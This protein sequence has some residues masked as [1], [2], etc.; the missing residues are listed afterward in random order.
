MR[1][2]LARSSSSSSSSSPT[3][4]YYY[5]HVFVVSTV[6]S[7]VSLVYTRPA[8]TLFRVD[9]DDRSLTVSTMITTM[10]ISST[11]LKDIKPGIITTTPTAST[12]TG[13]GTLL[14]VSPDDYYMEL[15]EDNR[16][17]QQE[18]RM[19]F[20]QSTVG[21]IK[22]PPIH[23]DLETDA[24]TTGAA[25]AAADDD[26]HDHDVIKKK[27][28]TI[29]KPGSDPTRTIVEHEH[30]K[31]CGHLR[32]QWLRN[33]PMSRLAKS[34]QHHQ[35]NC[36]LPIARHT[37][38]NTFGLGSH[39][40][41]W[42]QA[43]CNAIEDGFR[44]TE[45][46]SHVDDLWIWQDQG[47]CNTNTDP[48]NK[49]NGDQNPTQQRISASSPMECY[50]PVTRRNKCPISSS[51]Q[52]QHDSSIM[53]NVTDP[54]LEK[55]WCTLTR[56]TDDI[57]QKA[58]VRASLTEYLFSEISPLVVKEA[59][60]QIGII[61]QD[62]GSQ[63]PNDLVTVH[64]RWG[65]KFWEMDLPSID[66]YIQGVVRVLTGSNETI[67]PTANI[68]LATEDPKAYKAFIDAK[69]PGWKVFADITLQEIDA[70]RPPKG[71]RASWATRNTQGRAGF[72]AMGSLLV[73]LEAK[74]FVLTTKSNW[75]TMMNHLRTN[76]V[77]PRCN[78]CTA[79][80]DLRPGVW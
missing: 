26:D 38:D 76:I 16:Q 5:F 33:P 49:N 68:F 30:A 55:Q 1:A 77:D 48:K 66:E 71:N 45:Q 12:K 73:S 28:N 72:I 75:S 29:K 51:S 43:L 20:L 44:M 23:L 40:S 79:M 52:Q 10:K 54:R 50:L 65:D 42:G 21:C 22:H 3:G 39:F 37:L 13:E 19:V 47:H 46:L 74:Y 60:R 62:V 63:V 14:T 27:R 64:I 8:L 9:N 80:V 7:V 18:E 17:K 4:H 35:S 15:D 57:T 32:R 11:A 2:S 78:N 67:P 58:S 61:F 25:A 53:V 31:V 56:T 24:E 59:Q 6:I 36:S 34:F 69:P 41:L 70:F